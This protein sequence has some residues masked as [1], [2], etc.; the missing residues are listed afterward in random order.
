MIIVLCKDS[1]FKLMHLFFDLIVI[2]K[3][4][5]TDRKHDLGFIGQ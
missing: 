3:I 5:H 1:F 2:N 4:T